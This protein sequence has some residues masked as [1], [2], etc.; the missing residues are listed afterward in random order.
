MKYTLNEYISKIKSLPIKNKYTKEEILTQDF[1][2]DKDNRL[3]IYYAPHN[4]YINSKAKIFII[5]ITPGF[6]QMSTAM[7]T[8]REGIE[9]GKS[10]E[11]IKYDCKVAGRFSGSLR[12]NII[13][14]L[15]EINLNKSLNINSCDELF[16]EKDYL[17]HTTSLIPYPVFFKGNNYTGH[18]PKLMKSEFLMKY[19]YENLIENIEKLG[20]VLIIPLGNAVEEV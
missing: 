18:S 14:M 20:D 15:D 17:L 9:N 1:L 6:Q 13:S 8:A 19:V 16:K 7:A 10:I 5:G 11:E 2:I 3:E 12:K 4:E